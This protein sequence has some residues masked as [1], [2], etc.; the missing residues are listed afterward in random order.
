[1][2]P[3]TAFRVLPTWAVCAA[4]AAALAVAMGI[5]RFV[6]TPLLPLMQR[7]GLLSADGG[8][9]LAA[10]NYLGYL[11]GALTAARV[12]ASPRT[13]VLGA[14]L[15]T[16][17]LT[18]ATGWFSGLQ[19][20]LLLRLGAGV[21]SA[22]ALVGIGSWAMP[23]LAQ[24]GRAHAG[25]WVFAGVGLGI[26]L[27]GGWVWLFAAQSTSMLWLQL[28]ALAL[29]LSAAVVW[30]WRPHAVRVQQPPARRSPAAMPRGSWGLV[31][32]YGTLGFGYILPATYLPALARSLIDDPRLFGLIWPA[33]GLAA[34]ASTLL[35]GRALRRCHGLQI[36]SFSHVLMAAGCALPL[37]TR[38][39]AGLTLSALCVGGTFMVATMVGLQQVR[40]LAP[41]NPAPLLGRMTAAFACGQIA[42]PLVALGL[43]RLPTPGWSGVELTLGLAALALLASARWLH[44]A[45]LQTLLETSDGHTPIA[46]AS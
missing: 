13:L 42:G 43:A 40:T 26:A 10:A 45:L 22:W 20:W 11:F 27:A 7:E 30:A 21:L 25:G 1:M 39:G 14:L 34:A 37:L 9:L 15:G 24:R 33:F 19:V 31:L 5:G 8:A 18:A 2:R 23:T 36:W 44:R 41:L 38:S 28:G 32:C 3:S 35:A 29:L 17:L 12:P 4:G 16:A 6:F 46:R